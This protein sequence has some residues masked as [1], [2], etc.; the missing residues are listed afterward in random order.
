[1]LV[2]V[3]VLALVGI[4]GYVVDANE[5]GIFDQYGDGCTC[6]SALPTTPPAQVDI[7]GLPVQYT[8]DMVYVI[9]V[10]V[11]EG[12]PPGSGGNNAEGGF[13]LNVSAGTLAPMPGPP[14]VQVAGSQATH[15]AQGNDQRA[16]DI[17]W[18][19]PPVGM[20][21]VNFTVAAVSVDGDA[22]TLGDTWIV[23]TY[24]IPETGPVPPP[25]VDLICP[26]GG[27]DLTGGSV[28]NIEYEP[29]SEGF[30][31]DQLLI[32]IN[33]SL[34]G[35]VNLLPTGAQGIPGTL[36]SP[37]VYAWTLPM[38]NTMQARVI[39]EVKDPNGAI[40]GDMSAADFE[41]DSAPPMIVS[42]EP[43]GTDVVP[44][45]IIRVGFD[46]GMNWIATEASFSLNDTTTWTPVAG[47]ISWA[48]NVMVFTPGASL[49]LGTEYNANVTSG[50]MDDSDPGNNMV[51]LFNWTFTVA[52]TGD[53]EPPTI[54]DVTAVPSPQEYPGNVNISAIVED[55]VSVNSVWVN[56]TY[57]GAVDYLEGTMDYDSANDR[58]YFESSYPL[59]G[60]YDFTVFAN[61]TKSNLNS[62]SGHTFDIED[63]TPP[64]I[65]HVP[66]SFSFADTTINIT[67]NVVD[68]YV[69]AP[70]NPVWLAY[71]NVSEDP[72]NVSMT[73]AGGG[74]YWHEIPAQLVEGYVNYSLWATDEY[75]NDV[76]TAVFTIQIVTTDIFPPEIL[77][78][79]AQPSPQER[80]E[81]VNITA[82]VR[83][84]SGLLSVWVV[85][86]QSGTEIYNETM[87]EGLNDVYYMEDR[88]DIVGMYDFTIWAE[89]NNNVVSS[90]SDTFEI[91]D[92]TPPAAPTGLSVAAGD[93][94]GTLEVT[95]SANTEQDIDGYDLY[96]S[97]TGANNTFS[98]INTDPLT[99]TSH[100]D[101]GLED[102]TTYY[103]MLKAVDDE[104]LESEFSHPADGTTIT[105]SDEEVDY[106]WLYA[107]IAILVILVVV[108]A[109]ASAAR[110]KPSEEEE[111]ELE[112]L[113]EVGEEYTAEEGEE[114]AEEETP[115]VF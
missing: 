98:K 61:D 22:S 55:N 102:N 64:D 48:M 10:T 45:A 46:E 27:E 88:Y 51:A 69:L 17:E 28:H 109:A 23:R 70:V 92:T 36:A 47:T 43:V 66:V 71:T 30:P 81:D 59:V 85:V 78:V 19:A 31:K 21:D 77:D 94:A 26:D 113:D 67:A 84:L 1:M 112:E 63:T 53:L 111:E 108:L 9:T 115:K 104:G 56:V 87:T 89:D 49:Q 62:S 68:A 38:E 29:A 101:T 8:P 57:P 40:G 103:Y 25:T 24:I 35:G 52:S 74:D 114:A 2:T 79:Q 65:T 60:T 16:W 83:D 3:M 72:S 99:G 34:D 14:R 100:T 90:S 4:V 107:L 37:N 95:W 110:K 106:M 20:G 12:P 73:S 41:I 58:Y 54:S 96:R 7:T 13:N 75:G 44:S 42:K 86:T 93:D 80:Y 39:V 18:T 91:V 5:T 11:S 105:P 50:A 82:T 33:Y 32:W 6:H 97:D 15:T 76:M